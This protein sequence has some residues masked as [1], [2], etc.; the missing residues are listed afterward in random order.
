MTKNEYIARLEDLLRNLLEAVQMDTA[1]T[2]D[3][4][5]A[6]SLCRAYAEAD[7]GFAYNWRKFY[8]GEG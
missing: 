4:D 5:C 1:R 2:C 3:P 7:E 6:C 8:E